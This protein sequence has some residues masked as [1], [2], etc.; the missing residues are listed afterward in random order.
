MNQTEFAKLMQV[1][2]GTVTRWKDRGWLVMAGD[3][4]VDVEASKARLLERRG[5]LGKIDARKASKRSGWS[6]S[7][8]CT[9]HR[10][11]QIHREWNGG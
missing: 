6:R 7:P 11:L 2:Q 5:T 9:T 10:A 4:Q 3:C 8:H 1:H